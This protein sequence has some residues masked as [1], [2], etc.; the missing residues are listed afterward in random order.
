VGGVFTSNRAAT[1][2]Y[3]MFV[4]AVVAR[5]NAAVMILAG[6][7]THTKENITCLQQGKDVREDELSSRERGSLFGR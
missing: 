1:P 3:D 7:Q 2:H 5:R 6:T 4:D